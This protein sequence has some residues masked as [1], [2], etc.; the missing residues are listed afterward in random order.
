MSEPCS[1]ENEL[2]RLQSTVEMVRKE[3]FNGDN[4]LS[5]SVPVLSKQVGE[6]TDAV[7][8]LRTSIDEFKEFK[9]KAF[10]GKTVADN[11]AKEGH[12][13]TIRTVMWIT[14]IVAILAFLF[15]VYNN[16]RVGKLYSNQELINLQ[17]QFKQDKVL[18]STT[19][20]GYVQY[21]TVNDSIK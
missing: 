7:K 19:R 18:D 16:G 4:A 12:N 1:K 3:I 5:K 21:E 8:D 13:K 11:A 20:G 6:L 17:M 14:A 15:N 2:G 9:N 10:G